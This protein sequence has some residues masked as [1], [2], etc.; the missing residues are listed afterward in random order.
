[1]PPASPSPAI[2][3]NGSGAGT[4]TGDCYHCGLGFDT[5]VGD[6]T[7]AHK[8]DWIRGR[9]RGGAKVVMVGDGINDA[10][11]LAAADA[12]ISFAHATDLA[13]VNSHLLVLGQDLSILARMR[14][15]ARETRS[16]IRQNL[17]WAAS[18]T[19]LTVPFAALGYI[20]PWGAAIGMSASSLLVVPNAIRL[21]G[22]RSG[23][24]AVHNR[25]T[26]DPA[27]TRKH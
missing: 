12:S 5:A 27:R 7:P 24:T 9:Q 20:A 19:F 14:G 2:N 18:Y 21:R 17:L 8:P 22:F 1:M 15:L 23:S 25:D 4:G 3:H 13:Q 10:P 11:T 26:G 16:V 6:M